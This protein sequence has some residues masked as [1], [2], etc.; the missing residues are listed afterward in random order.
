MEDL[1]EEPELEEREEK[2]E[3]EKEEDVQEEGSDKNKDQSQEQQQEEQEKNENN[4]Q[5]NE[6]LVRPV[7]NKA[8]RG[9][10]TD[11]LDPDDT[12]ALL[13]T[14]FSVTGLNEIKTERIMPRVNNATKNVT[15]P[16]RPISLD[17]NAP[18]KFRK[19]REGAWPEKIT[20][21]LIDG[22]EVSL[23]S[24]GR[25]YIDTAYRTQDK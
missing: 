21:K 16:K 10:L 9:S 14:N 17:L 4:D 25:G 19:L 8:R 18:I 12:Q 11:E 23:Q 20:A 7:R 15:M 5:D 22:D 13:E 24:R 3:E 6:P 1:R 2:E